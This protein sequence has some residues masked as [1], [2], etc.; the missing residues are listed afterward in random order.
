MLFVRRKMGQ[1]PV[2]VFQNIMEIPILVAGQNV[3]LTLTAIN[4]RLA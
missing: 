2:L 1:G 3:F 4:Q